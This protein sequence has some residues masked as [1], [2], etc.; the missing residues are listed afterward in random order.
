MAEKDG[1]AVVCY[2]CKGEG[3]YE[4]TYEPFVERKTLPEG[5][6]KRVFKGS[7]GYGHSANDVTTKEGRTILFSHG[8]CTYKEWLNGKQPLPVRG[9]YCPFIWT[10]Q[11][12]QSNDVNDLY[13]TRCEG[14]LGCCGNKISDCKHYLDKADCWRIF[15]EEKEQL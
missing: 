1:C 13:K 6:V 10:S 4:I 14:G 3:G 2:Q 11:K 12:L 9:L 8:G 5:E 7:F 15:E